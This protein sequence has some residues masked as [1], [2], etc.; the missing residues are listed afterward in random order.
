MYQ[1]VTTLL[2]SYSIHSSKAYL[3]KVI[4]LLA[5]IDLVLFT[6][7]FIL[8]Y[9][10]PQF[11]NYRDAYSILDAI[12]IMIFFDYI[13]I[14]F[15]KFLN[16]MK[17]FIDNKNEIRSTKLLIISINCFFVSRIFYKLLNL[18]NSLIEN[19]FFTKRELWFGIYMFVYY[20]F[21]ELFPCIM[22]F[23]TMKKGGKDHYMKIDI[24]FKNCNNIISPK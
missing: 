1:I 10:F 23:N 6:I 24:M 17:K 14:F 21:N 9:N 15:F 22:I 7:L 11:K 3:K 13:M 5:I 16:R 20:I 19:P 4:I 12:I 2:D 18:V 8:G